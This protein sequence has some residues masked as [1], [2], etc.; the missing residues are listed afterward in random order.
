MNDQ[1]LRALDFLASPRGR[2]VVAQ[3]LY[4]GIRTLKQHVRERIEFDAEKNDIADMEYLREIL[5]SF[6]ELFYTSP[7]E[8]DSSICSIC[9]KIIQTN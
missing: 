7:G 8:V 6:P 3:A 1:E 4:H 9:S 2:Y 5:F